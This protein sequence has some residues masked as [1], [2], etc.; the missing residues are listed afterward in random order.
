MAGNRRPGEVRIAAEVLSRAHRRRL[1]YS[2]VV[3]GPH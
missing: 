3:T 2:R 1:P